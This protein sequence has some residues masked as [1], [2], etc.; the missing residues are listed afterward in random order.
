MDPRSDDN[1]LAL[2]Q[3]Y[4][5]RS[6]GLIRSDCDLGDWK[7]ADSRAEKG[8]IVRDSFSGDF[9]FESL[10][11]VYVRHNGFL[12]LRQLGETFL[13]LKHVSNDLAIGV[14]L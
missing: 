7:P 3:R 4:A 14:R 6:V 13:H 8:P 1:Y 5:D 11:L 2:S 9:T 12:G 10:L